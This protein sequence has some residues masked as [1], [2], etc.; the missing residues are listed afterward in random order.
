MAVDEVLK[1]TSLYFIT[2]FISWAAWKK[3]VS[4]DALN[5]MLENVA[6]DRNMTIGTDE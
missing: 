6:Q 4:A 1:A 2:A 3:H 5:M